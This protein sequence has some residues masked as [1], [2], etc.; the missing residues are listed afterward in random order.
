MPGTVERTIRIGPRVVL[1]APDGSDVVLH[2]VSASFTWVGS[3]LS[4]V[5]AHVRVD[6]ATWQ[7]ID[8]G[9]WFQMPPGVRSPTFGGSFREGEDV[10]LDL[11]LDGPALTGMAVT[12]DDEW[13]AGAQI[14]G[15][16]N[17]TNAPDEAM[18]PGRMNP[19]VGKTESWKGLNAKQVLGPGLKGGFQTVAGGWQGSK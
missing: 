17:P 14:R 3:Q 11:F 16:R 13:E 12:A 1:A 19:L 10:E 6:W 4:R 5:E 18:A 8:A 9:H 7:R 2:D 15:G